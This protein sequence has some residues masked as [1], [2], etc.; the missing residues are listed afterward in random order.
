MT[1]LK[2]VEL[3]PTFG[4]NVVDLAR[5]KGG[6]LQ[7]LIS[8]VVNPFDVVSRLKFRASVDV[9]G[10][11]DSPEPRIMISSNH[12]LVAY[13]ENDSF[14]IHLFLPSGSFSLR[15]EQ[16]CTCL[17]LLGDG[18]LVAGNIAGEIELWSLYLGDPILEAKC[19]YRFNCGP[20]GVFPI[21]ASSDLDTFQVVLNRGKCMLIFDTVACASGN[22]DESSVA[23][24]IADLLQPQP[25]L[26]CDSLTGG[27]LATVGAST[28][29]VT[30]T[31]NHKSVSFDCD[32]IRCMSS[33]DLGHLFLVT[34]QGELVD[35]AW[36]QGL[37]GVST[38]IK[39]VDS[40]PS[41][42][43]RVDITVDPLRVDLVGSRL[44]TATENDLL[45]YSVKRTANQNQYPVSPVVTEFDLEK[46]LP[47]RKSIEEQVVSVKI[48]GR[49]ACV[50]TK[51]SNNEV[52]AV[53]VPL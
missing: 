41:S 44:I 17:H 47:I 18:L 35:C 31:R 43:E 49:N 9:S 12:D 27:L 34:S 22:T 19:V 45:V 30:D 53:Y 48:C 24:V 13:C 28:V 8:R 50:I 7:E 32:A 37:V 11:P 42:V 46:Q 6:K 25:L 29:Y 39:N 51:S 36:S 15:L 5:L 14:T 23:P 10:L 33:Q 2:R 26:N 52:K 21:L 38:F 16:P 20:A 1:E 3:P 40:K 4:V